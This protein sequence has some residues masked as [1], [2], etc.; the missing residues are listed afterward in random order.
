[1]GKAVSQEPPNG[2]QFKMPVVQGVKEFDVREKR[3]EPVELSASTANQLPIT[4][5]V[6]LSWRLDPSQ[7]MDVYIN[8][9]TPEQ[10]ETNVIN[11]RMQ[12][13]AKEGLAKYQASELVRDRGAASET[14]RLLIVEALE[15]YPANVLSVQIENVSLPPQ[16]LEAVMNKERAREA[17]AQEQYTLE[18][19]KLEAQREVQTAELNRDATKARADGEAYRIL[20]EAEAQAELIRVIGEAHAQSIADMRSA[21][22]SDP[23]V[24]EYSKIQQWD[25]ILPKTVLSSDPEL[26]MEIPQ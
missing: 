12:Q 17:A 22:D 11:P 26:L 15:H 1:M 16:Y 4:A 6:T 24:L 19:Q 10:F 9:G 23:V 18:R 13:A 7:V 3:T 2:L 20:T 5:Q 8:Y 14:I 21:L 25:G